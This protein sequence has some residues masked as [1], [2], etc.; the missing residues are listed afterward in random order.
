MVRGWGLGRETCH[1]STQSLAV[2]HCGVQSIV[3]KDQ[4]SGR[5]QDGVEDGSI[6]DWSG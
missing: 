2:A 3:R 4:C 5:W 1:K 6:G